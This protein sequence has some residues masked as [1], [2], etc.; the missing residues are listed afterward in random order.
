SA[1][2]VYSNGK[3]NYRCEI[4][5]LNTEIKVNQ[6]EQWNKDIEQLSNF[7]KQQITLI[8]K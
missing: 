8:K 4:N 3:L 2:Y 1:K 6:F 5:L 7:Y